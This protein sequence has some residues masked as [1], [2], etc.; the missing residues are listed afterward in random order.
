[1]LNN[2]CK[3]ILEKLSSA[4]KK[5]YRALPFWSWNDKLCPDELIRQ[6]NRMKEQG[7]G[8]FFMHA[9]GGLKTEYLSDEWF[10]CVKACVKEAEKLGMECWAYDENGCP[11]VLRTANY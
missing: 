3:K 10:D 9:R 1:M 8:G 4:E 2:D 11:A 6:I 7:F 5:D